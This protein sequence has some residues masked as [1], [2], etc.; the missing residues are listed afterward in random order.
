M[1]L[2]ISKNNLLNSI[3]IVSKAVPNRTTM[4]IL[5]CIMIDATGSHIYLIANDMEMGIQNLTEGEIIENGK[6]M[7]NASIFSNLVRKL[8]ENIVEITTVG[9]KVNIVC[10]KAKFS[11]LGKTGEDFTYLPD[12]ERNEEIRISQYTLR[13]MIQKTI[14]SISSSDSSGM[15]NGELLE[16]KDNH[17]KMVALDGHRVAIR[18]VELKENYKDQKV[19]IAG[20]T[21]N[22]L[23]KIIGGSVDKTVSMYFTQKHALFEFDNTL[24]VTRLIDGNYYNI[25]SMLQSTFSTQIKVNRQELINCID[26]STLLV[27]EDDKKPIIFMISDSS[28]ELKINTTIG[29]MNEIIEINKTGEN[30]NIGFNPKFLLDALRAIDD[31]EVMICLL[32]PKAPCFIR[33]DEYCYLVLPVNF[34]TID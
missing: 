9:E 2:R 27:R 19:I 21:L 23:S 29:S 4:S 12:I 32:S 28:M 26:R 14:F 16:I 15:M 30:M 33:N 20:R 34:I 11:I 1:K 25:D 5:E 8:P 6:I 31:E 22:E 17:L 3:N 24:M 13:N 18:N 10:E 7:I